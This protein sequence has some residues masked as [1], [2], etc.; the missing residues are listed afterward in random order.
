[1]ACASLVCLCAVLLF[2][3]GRRPFKDWEASDIVSAQVQLIPPGETIQITDIDELVSYLNELV[4][5]KA[6]NSYMEYAGQSVVFTLSLSDGTQMEITDYNLGIIING[7]GYK[8]KYEPCEEL[9]HYAN[10]LL[11]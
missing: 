8:A 4:I 6:D 1:M 11:S 3:M 10:R 9:N 5:Y 7:V 2:F